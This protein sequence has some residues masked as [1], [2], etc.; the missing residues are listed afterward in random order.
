MIHYY[1]NKV[2]QGTF[3]FDDAEYNGSEYPNDI[4]NMISNSIEIT[5]SEFNQLQEA[6]INSILANNEILNRIAEY[7]QLL[8]NTD[9]II[10]KIYEAS[11][12]GNDSLMEQLKIEYADVIAQRQTWR[13]E[14]N[15]LQAQI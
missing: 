11:I 5:E 10:I 7:S 6:F 2:G 13:N 14:I 4:Q 15:A 3:S 9:Y 12:L 8:Q 1:K